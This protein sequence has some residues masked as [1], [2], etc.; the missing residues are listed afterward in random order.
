MYS[1]ETNIY[2]NPE[3]ANSAIKLTCQISSSETKI[4]IKFI[5]TKYQVVCLNES[6]LKESTSNFNS[7]KNQISIQRRI[8]KELET[9]EWNFEEDKSTLKT[10]LRNQTVSKYNE[11]IAARFSSCQRFKIRFWHPNSKPNFINWIAFQYLSLYRLQNFCE[12][13]RERGGLIWLYSHRISISKTKIWCLQS[14]FTKRDI[15]L[16]HL[17]QVILGRVVLCGVV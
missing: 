9:L 4:K 11:N 2:P 13:I 17:G 12:Y 5:Y 10:E 1:L 3:D 14:H 16:F 8:F 7:K 6:H 15:C